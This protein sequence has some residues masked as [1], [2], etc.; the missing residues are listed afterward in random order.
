MARREIPSTEAP[1]EAGPEL[2]RASSREIVAAL[3][4]EDR[5]ALDAV[6][7]V[8]DDV[9]RAADALAVVLREGGRWFYAGAGTS[10][11]LAC[12]DA[13][14]LPPTFGIE[15]ERVVGVMAGGAAALSRAQEGA[16]DDAEAARRTLAGLGLGAADAVVAVS[17]S[18]STP[19]ALAALEAART[20][21]GRRIAITCDPGSPLAAAAQIAIAP[22]TGPELIAGSTRMKAGLAQ[23]MVL[24]Q[25]STAVMVRLGRVERNRMTWLRPG[26]RKLWQRAVR[27]VMELGGVD[28]TRA[29]AL[30]ERAGGSAAEALNRLRGRPADAEGQASSSSPRGKGPS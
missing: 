6:A 15:P 20:A 23:K 22:D 8:L 9:A 17:A 7:A 19:F 29:R 14:E 4:A 2:D 30:L 27:L 28:E 11:R 18:G 1:L 21:G 16:E 25:L 13:A 12:A 24:T 26:S 3:L 5:R 10:G